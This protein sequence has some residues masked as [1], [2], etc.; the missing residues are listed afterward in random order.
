MFVNGSVTG[1]TGLVLTAV[2]RC[3]RRLESIAELALD[4]RLQRVRSAVSATTRCFNSAWDSGARSPRPQ[5][6]DRRDPAPETDA[7]RRRPK[8]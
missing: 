7:N 6:E 1:L 3:R 8:R 2:V 4:P 5:G